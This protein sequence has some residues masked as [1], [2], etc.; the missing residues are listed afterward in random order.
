MR[1]LILQTSIRYLVPLQLMFS[2][3]LLLGG[4]QGPGGGFV[5]G[6][7]AAS[8]FSIYAIAYGVESARRILHVDPIVLIGTGLFM[9][10]TSGVLGLLIDGQFMVHQW[11]ERSYPGIKQLNTPVL[12]D[13]GVYAVVVGV[14]LLIIFSLI[15]EEA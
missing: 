6:L 13:A 4:H 1:S 3:F 12:F 15:E 11:G 5:G 14:T 7:V 10:L 2:I 8:A 9:A